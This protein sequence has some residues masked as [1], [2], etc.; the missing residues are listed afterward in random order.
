MVQ[1]IFVTALLCYPVGTEAGLE[2]VFKLKCFELDFFLV[3]VLRQ[4]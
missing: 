1:T 2:S 3:R 4:V